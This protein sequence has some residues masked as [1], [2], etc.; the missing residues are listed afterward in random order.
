MKRYLAE[1]LLGASLT[2][3]TV[4]K[5]QPIGANHRVENICIIQ[6]PRVTVPDF[7]PVMQEGFSKHGITSEFVTNRAGGNCQYTATY[8]AR[9][10]WDFATYLSVAQ[11]SVQRNGQQIANANYHL[12]NKG[13][14]ALNKWASVRSK[15]LPV[16]EELLAQLPK[17]SAMATGTAPAAEQ[18]TPVQLTN[19]D[20]PATTELA[21]KLAQLKDAYDAGLLTQEEHD[22]KRK[23]L[24]QQL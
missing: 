4:V 7:V 19:A 14:F 12:R 21:V 17:G 24:I 3:C 8:N 11:I 23:E 5:V 10:S 18:G 1:A 20:P 9:R 6:N 22:A 16:M 2:G 13:G 15:I